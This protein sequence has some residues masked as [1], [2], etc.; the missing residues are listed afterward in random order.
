VFCQARI[1]NFCFYF[2]CVTI[3]TYIHKYIVHLWAKVPLL[4]VSMVT[5]LIIRYICILS[6]Y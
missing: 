3:N 5:D 4:M 1:L 2:I 6:I